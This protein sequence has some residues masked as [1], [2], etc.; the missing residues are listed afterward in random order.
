MCLSVQV[1]TLAAAP[2]GRCLST[3]PLNLEKAGVHGG[4]PKNS[5]AT[6]AGK[7]GGRQEEWGQETHMLSPRER[8]KFP[9]YSHVIKLPAPLNEFY[10]LQQISL[11]ENDNSVIGY[12]RHMDMTKI[13]MVHSKNDRGLGRTVAQRGACR[14]ARKKGQVCRSAG[15]KCPM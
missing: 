10:C 8:S 5:L 11:K 15:G 9:I 4:Q 13:E 3:P 2:L 12:K 1:P 14:Q 7:G 6:E